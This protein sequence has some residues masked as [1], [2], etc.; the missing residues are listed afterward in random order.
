MFPNASF[1]GTNIVNGPPSVITSFV[2]DVLMSLA[3]TENMSIASMVS[4]KVCFSDMS[5]L[6]CA[7]SRAVCGPNGWPRGRVFWLSASGLVD[8]FGED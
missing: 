7:N 3:N 8:G 6:L 1:V 2:P 5:K 4:L